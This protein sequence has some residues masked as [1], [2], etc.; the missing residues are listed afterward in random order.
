MT[1]MALTDVFDSSL[2]GINTCTAYVGK[3]VFILC[4][5]VCVCLCVCVCVCV[6]LVFRYLRKTYTW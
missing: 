5:C 2:S 1:H 4:V 6:C 3:N